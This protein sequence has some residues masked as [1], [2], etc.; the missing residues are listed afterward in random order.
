MDAV[1]A[2]GLTVPANFS[3]VGFV[4]LAQGAQS[5]PG[6]TTVRQPLHDMGQDAARAPLSLIE[7][8]TCSWSRTGIRR[9]P[10]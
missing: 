6:L 9:R 4:D 3:V 5:F 8:S 2:C 7:D 1:S 10:S